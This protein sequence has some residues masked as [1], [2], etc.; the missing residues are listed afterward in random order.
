[1]ASRLA[2]PLSG[3]AA[4]AVTLGVAEL[5]AAFLTR[6]VGTE[7]TPSPVL[8]VG[9]AFVDLTPAWLK[10][11]AVAAFGT[12]DKAALFV[13]M[14]LTLTVLCALLGE[15]AQR[16]PTPGLVAFAVV[17]G[18]GTAAVLSRPGA[19]IVDALPTLV[20]T[21]AGL[22]V[23]AWLTA[24]AGGEAREHGAGP[25]A[26]AGPTTPA[27]TTRRRSVVALGGGLTVVGLLGLAAGRVLTQAQAA[28][29]VAREDV[30]RRL[31][32]VPRLTRRVEVPAG[33]D[34]REPGTSTFVTPN[35]SFYRIDTALSVPQVD[36]ATWRLRVHGMVDNEVE[37]TFDELLEQE[38]VETLAT[39]TCV[40]NEV[41]GNLVGNAVW[42]GWP[43]R[44][45][46]ARA[47]VHSDADMVLSTSEDGWTAGTPLEVLTDDRDAILA[48][49]MNGEPL[50]PQHGFPVRLVVPGL[51]GYV[52]ATKWVVDLLVTRFD[53]DEGYWTPR[54]WSERGPVKTQS[55]I[56]V[57]RQGSDV[58]AG[59][60]VIAGVAWD[61]HTGIE[62][63]EV[64]VDGGEW[65]EAQLAL[66]PSVDAWRQWRLVWEAE[67]G[68]HTVVVRAT[69]RDGETQ[70]D[71]RQPPAPSGATGR[72]TIDVTVT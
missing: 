33:A 61:Q 25:T 11:L 58:P 18:V 21:L 16:R 35:D 51:Y 6:V 32:R 5:T 43:V 20:G 52:S 69:N 36:P 64:Q 46:L 50:P 37:M 3:V 55:R 30:G 22:S 38:M 13:G 53:R 44:E 26:P 65:Q 70:T 27:G 48:V 67:P 47:G 31:A 7:G 57:P 1:M 68:E 49:S 39:L 34:F 62:R 24:R 9:E 54:G 45:L 28:V 23:L 2:A 59:R 66:E 10:D 42:V 17:G 4:G 29:E 71:R 41:G 72:H 8:A 63:V 56:D 12:S 15:L 40:S 60:A 14:G 19:G